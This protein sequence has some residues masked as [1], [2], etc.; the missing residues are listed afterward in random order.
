MLLYFS[1]KLSRGVRILEI[2]YNQAFNNIHAVHPSSEGRFGDNLGHFGV[3]PFP[4]V[5]LI[6]DAMLSEHPQNRT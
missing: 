3:L 2:S 4:L 6:E 1:S 5:V